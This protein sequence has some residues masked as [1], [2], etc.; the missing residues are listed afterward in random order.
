M[1]QNRNKLSEQEQKDILSTFNK[2]V[3]SDLE[4]SVTGY[5]EDSR[6]INRRLER[7]KNA[8]KIM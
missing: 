4:N 8:G 3:V 5:A 2:K 1:I 7:L 6:E